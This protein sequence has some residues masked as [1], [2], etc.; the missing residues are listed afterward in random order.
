MEQ[1]SNY[2]A[3]VR[4]G[5][6]RIFAWTMIWLVSFF[7]ARFASEALNFNHHYLSLALIV[8]S[9]IV[10]IKM[11]LVVAKTLKTWD[12]LDRLMYYKA[13]A[14]TCGLGILIS[15]TY[16]LLFAVVFSSGE[17]KISHLILIL[18]LIFM[19]SLIREKMRYQ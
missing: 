12:E 3:I 17:P 18:C 19:G 9:F 4:Q 2:K 6:K 16:E 15:N 8:V 13:C 10:G 14:I 7:T 5:E 11:L 1:S